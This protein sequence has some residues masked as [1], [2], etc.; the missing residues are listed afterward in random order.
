MLNCV[1]LFILL[2]ASPSVVSRIVLNSL[3]L[4]IS[5]ALHSGL[6]NP[7]FADL[8]RT[9]AS[10]LQ[11]RAN[12]GAPEAMTSDKQREPAQRNLEQTLRSRPDG[13]QGQIV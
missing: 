10:N 8:W 9:V 7:N 1:L 4:E 3:Q 11:V 12:P 2:Y 5:R 6:G 13:N